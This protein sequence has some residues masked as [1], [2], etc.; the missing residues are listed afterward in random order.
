VPPVSP[1]RPYQ[2]TFSFLSN[3]ALYHTLQGAF[4]AIAREAVQKVRAGLLEAR[5]QQLEARLTA[6]MSPEAESEEQD[7]D[8]EQSDAQ[9]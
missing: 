5:V 9:P 2:V 8:Q 7:R 3:R 6:T 4:E 1:D